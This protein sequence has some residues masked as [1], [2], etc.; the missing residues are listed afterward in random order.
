MKQTSRI[1]L[2]LLLAVA[3]GAAT[4][5]RSQAAKNLLEFRHGDRL[6][7]IGNTLA[8][9]MQHHAWLETYIHALHPSH[10]LTFRNLGFA[11]DEIAA[12]NGDIASEVVNPDAV[13]GQ[14]VEEMI[15]P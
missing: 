14:K 5:A 6:C 12:V 10:E 2:Y 4:A 9:R 13:I 8:D 11:G 3:C 15:H 7:Y 1:V